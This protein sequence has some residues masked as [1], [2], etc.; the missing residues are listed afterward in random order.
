MGIF[1]HS[2]NK[3][4]SQST[5]NFYFGSVEAEGEVKS[6]QSTL[7][8]FDDY[9]NILNKLEEGKFIFTG[10]KG[11]G[12]SA[13]AKFIKDKS[14]NSD[15]SYATILRLSDFQVHKKIQDENEVEAL[16]FEWLILVQLV[17]LIIKSKTTIYTQ[18]FGKLKKFLDNNTGMVSID[19]YQF[20][21]GLQKTGGEVSFGVL[22][23]V[24][25]GI[26]K[27][28]FDVKVSRAPF[29]KLLPALKEIVETILNFEVNREIEYWLLF[30]DLDINFDVK[31]KEDNERVMELIRIAKNFNNEL[32]SKSKAKL[33][34]FLREDIRDN[35]ITKFP[36]SAKIF[37]SY[38]ININWFPFTSDQLDSQPLKQLANR[39]IEINFER[40]KIPFNNDPWSTLISNDNRSSF[41]YILD[42]T[43]YRPRDI[44]TLLTVISQNHYRIPISYKDQRI[45]LDKY[46]AQNVK[47]IKSEL[48]L[49]FDE[50]DKEQIF[51]EIFPY[52]SKNQYV[53]F[54]NL[55]DHVAT[56]TW[57]I[58]AKSVIHLLLDYSLIV[59][60]NS[61]GEL[62][63]NY[64]ENP[65][66]EQ[67]GQRMYL[68]L[69]KLIYHYYNRLA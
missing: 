13:I 7:E 21:E 43:F 58:D 44:I 59:Y 2:K 6:G 1:D 18:E 35:I 23:H 28:Y 22:S 33:L 66:M 9:L 46:I 3:S 26:L 25:G 64:R 47:E 40:L 37:A 45:I 4:I 51:K 62:F 69:H 31:S 14:V 17:K 24:F 16:L 50:N 12:K 29:F 53:T 38:E 8:Y 36:D 41:K 19:K 32:F 27:K 5:K 15:D 67:R 68:T 54:E 63:F 60:K 57:S 65:A 52:L 20:N 48:S 61:T 49:F 56:F 30:D 39:R 42:F 10:R 11:V 55:R 34:I